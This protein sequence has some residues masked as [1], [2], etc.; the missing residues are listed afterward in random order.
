MFNMF[1]AGCL[2]IATAALLMPGVS[3][4]GTVS[5]GNAMLGDRLP[6]QTPI[7][8]APSVAVEVGKPDF[9]S[10]IVKQPSSITVTPRL[11]LDITRELPVFVPS[12]SGPR[13]PPVVNLRGGIELSLWNLV[14]AV[15]AQQRGDAFKLVETSVAS[16]PLSQ[17]DS[18]PL[19]TVPLPP[20]MWLFVIGVLGIAGARITGLTP[21]S[22][23][24]RVSAPELSHGFRAAVPA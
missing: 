19:S 13:I 14:A 1:K 20:A 2:A 22:R 21:A 3:A 4:A 18:S 17:P 12:A 24:G 23:A 6:A 8:P 10:W 16:L 5:S 9:L 7:E 15:H 11:S